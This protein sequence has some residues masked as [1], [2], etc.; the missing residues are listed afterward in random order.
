[1]AETKGFYDYEL[2][3]TD[4]FMDDHVHGDIDRV[5][6]DGM[7]LKIEWSGLKL[8]DGDEL[9]HTIWSNT[10]GVV[11]IDLSTVLMPDQR[12]LQ[13]NTNTA[14]EKTCPYWLLVISS[15]F[16]ISSNS[17]FDLFHS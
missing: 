7:T 5:S 9:Y 14:G 16:I 13:V 12:I 17:Y 4:T 1:M 11:H 6:L 2:G 15:P 10:E 8:S 3:M